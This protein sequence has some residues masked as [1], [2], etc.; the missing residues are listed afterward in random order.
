[1]ISDSAF[2][3]ITS[4]IYT[5]TGTFLA[6]AK[7]FT[8]YVYIVHVTKATQSTQHVRRSIYGMAD[9]LVIN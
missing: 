1:M 8:V 3:G 5:Y 6:R 4:L 7:L 2:R 9:R